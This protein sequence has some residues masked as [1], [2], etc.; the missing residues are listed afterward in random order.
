MTFF[1]CTILLKDAKI[2]QMNFVLE[3]QK[4]SPEVCGLLSLSSEIWF[5]H[6]RKWSF[7]M[8]SRTLRRNNHYKN[9]GWSIFPMCC[10][11]QSPFLM[12]NTM[13]SP[14]SGG[15]ENLSISFDKYTILFNKLSGHPS[16]FYHVKE[17]TITGC[18][19]LHNKQ[20]FFTWL[21]SELLLLHNFLSFYFD[22][23]MVKHIH[24]SYGS[25]F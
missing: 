23:L 6:G 16:R 1:E 24:I 22:V 3:K 10:S 4:S 13:F 15:D 7:G 19:L 21:W 18:G 2:D 17:T 11:L 12:C 20:K 5:L 25:S 9:G 8:V 14:I